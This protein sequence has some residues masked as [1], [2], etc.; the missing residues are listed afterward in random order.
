MPVSNAKDLGGLGWRDASAA[1]VY[2]CASHLVST[3]LTLVTAQSRLHAAGADAGGRADDSD[4]CVGAGPGAVGAHGGAQ[5]VGW[6][7][8]A[9]MACACTLVVI[10]GEEQAVLFNNK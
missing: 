9:V 1:W 4:R 7:V 3:R 6:K 8:R 5:A 2:G 10:H